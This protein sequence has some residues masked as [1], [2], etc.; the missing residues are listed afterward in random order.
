MNSQYRG[1]VHGRSPV[2]RSLFCIAASLMMLVATSPAVG[3]D[4]PST[5]GMV[6]I[7]AGRVRVGTTDSQQSALVR[8][9]HI[10]PQVLALQT[11]RNVDVPGFWIDRYE[12]TNRQYREFVRATTHRRPIHWLAHG[13]P[14]QRGDYPITGVD[15]ED[16]VAYAK[17]A[18]KRLPCE[19][20]WEKAARGA[21]GRLWPWGNQWDPKAC[22]WGDSGEKPLTASAVPVG[23][24]PRDRSV[25]GVM[26]MAGNLAE[27]VEAPLPKPVQYTA[28]VKGGSFVNS[29]PWQFLCATRNAHPKGHGGLGYLGFRC[30]LDAPAPEN[31]VALKNAPRTAF[32]PAAPRS[33]RP[34]LIGKK[35]IQFLPI[36]NHDRERG[37]Y[38]NTMGS[39]F[40]TIA[41]QRAKTLQE[42]TPWRIEVR[43]PYL[44]DDRFTL[45]FENHWFRPMKAIEFDDDFTQAVLKSRF[46]DHLDVSIVLSAGRDFVD[47][48]YELENLR[49]TPQDPA[50]EM[51]FQPMGA[52]N[53]RD[54]DGT[55]TF[56]QTVTGF[57]ST[58]RLNR[59]VI[60]RLWCQDYTLNPATG[61]SSIAPE[62]QGSLIA[63][64]SR[65]RKWVVAP[66][67]MS[68]P[69]VRLFNNWEY[70]CLHCTPPS[71]LE[72][73]ERRVFKQRVYFLNGDLQDLVARFEADYKAEHSEKQ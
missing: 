5:D 35:P 66:T 3:T 13:Y 73:R 49:P 64:V 68:G 29:A 38:Q 60:E 53:F 33:P 39:T 41:S 72:A 63:I 30:A 9:Y 10:N 50:V 17:W 27:W 1:K 32:K 18:G 14:K 34:E 22:R 58:A 54:H 28:L 4:R 43:V 70:S 56:I 57:H 40:L 16:A 48:R 59:T 31:V 25:F 45:F 37:R 67:A 12:V 23:S 36:R 20:E 52:P 7:P 6:Y 24:Y 69:A 15:Y 19:V 62:K 42:T 71:R 55:R 47:I 44:P 65:D 26:D 2:E 11:S 61:T 46:K 51:C 21:D 8:E